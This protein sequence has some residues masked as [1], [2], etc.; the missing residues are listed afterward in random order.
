QVT[1]DLSPD[2]NSTADGKVYQTTYRYDGSSNRLAGIDQ[3]DGS[4]LSFTYLQVN[5]E[6]R[7]ETVTDGLNRVTRFAYDTSTR[8][9]TVFDAYNYATR[10]RYDTEGRLLS[11]S[12]PSTAAGVQSV[13]FQYDGDGNLFR[14]VDGQNNAV[15]YTYDAAGNQI[16]QQDDLGNRIERTYGSANQLLTETTFVTPDPD[17]AG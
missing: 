5:G 7:L 8:T 13:T 11:V 9:T 3:T 17:G 10:Y 2:D 1:V 12:A 6:Y 4:K 14:S 16:S 15:V